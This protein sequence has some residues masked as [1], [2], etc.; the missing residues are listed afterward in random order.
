M[1]NIPILIISCDKYADVWTPFFQI[2][3]Q[4]WSDC[5]FQIYIGSNHKVRDDAKVT[6]L[7][8]GDDKSWAD[9]V[10]KMIDRLPGDYA[11]LLLEDFL[12]TDTVDTARVRRLVDIAEQEQLGCLR[13]SPHPAP[14]KKL[15]RYSELGEIEYGADY[16]VSTQGAIWR[17]S[18]LRK[19]LHPS[20]SA[21]QFEQMGSPLSDHYPDK[22]WSVWEPAL[23]YRHG[24]ERGK[25]M[26]QG[27]DICRR[28][29]VTV[30][31]QA[32]PKMGE[33]DLAQSRTCHLKSKIASYLPRA[34]RRRIW[35]P[36]AV[37]H[38]LAE[39]NESL[40]REQ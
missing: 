32:R 11:I 6:T 27:L 10:R 19:L 2:F 18:T 13:L 39:L 40:M 37:N 7:A 12:F 31:L 33:Q 3:N 9:S 21:W 16:R 8:I 14:T 4:R 5:P 17:L 15:E 29:G 23:V 30:D 26:E 22:F 20:F 36:P 38:L 24:V 28:A 35:P 34:I 25:W 1:T